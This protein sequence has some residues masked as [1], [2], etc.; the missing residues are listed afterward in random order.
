M[1]NIDNIDEL[2]LNDSWNLY[3]H[4]KNNLKKYADNTTL[5]YNISSIKSLWEVYNNFPQP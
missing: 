3:F 2:I 4:A 5:I 1:S